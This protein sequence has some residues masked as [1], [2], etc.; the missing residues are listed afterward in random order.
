MRLP[1]I[2]LT[3]SHKTFREGEKVK[4]YTRVY[5]PI[6]LDA[7]AYNMQSMQNNL[8]PGTGMIGV[9]KTD[10]Y[11]HGAVPVAKAIDPYVK[12]YAVATIDEALILR[13]H[14]ITKPVLILGVTHASRYE[15]LID[16]EIRPAVFTMEQ[17]KPLSE[18]AVKK[19]KKAKIHLALDTGMSRIG[20]TPDE[21]GADLAA[22]IAALPGIEAEGLFT[23][24]ARADEADK[25]AAGVQL[26]RYLH[27]AELLRERGVEIPVKHCANSAAIMELPETHLDLARAGISIYGMYPSDEVLRERMPLKPVMGLKSYITYVKIIEAGTEVSY[28]GTFRAENTMR[29]A[30]VPVGYGDGYPRALSG[31]GYVLILGR[32]APILGRVCMDQMMVDVTEIPGAKTDTEVTLLGRDGAEEIT[33]E[34]LAR[35]SGG[36][37]YEIVCDIGKRVPRVYI[38]GGTV[39]GTKDYFDDRY[40]DFM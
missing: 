17:A 33:V 21:V 39:T 2:C 18:L 37:H 22:E 13:R 34:E 15:E 40:E 30:T 25:T 28:G 1:T 38:K 9:V 16:G 26:R 7:A 3:E 32:R 31:K 14:G 5:A 10:G 27:F 36:F 20:M 4:K 12:G 6:D 29:I 24:F 23:H 8:K 19:G 11:G 35:I